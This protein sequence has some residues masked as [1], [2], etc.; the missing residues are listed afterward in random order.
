MHTKTDVKQPVAATADRPFTLNAVSSQDGT[1]IGYRQYG[2]G[3]GIVLVQGAM[4]SV[5]N[6]SQ[7]ASQ[8]AD[9]FTVYVPDRRGRGLSPLP[10]HQDHTIQ[11]DAEDLE[12]LLRK[13][14]AHNVFALSSGAVI[15]LTTAASATTAIHKLVACEPPLFAQHPMPVAQIA[16]FDRAI[17]QGKMAAALT[18]AGKVV[19]PA[20][21]YIPSWLLTFFTSR[22]LA[23][24]GR[25][26][27]GDF[28]TLKELAMA[29]QY[30]FRVV[31]EM[32]GALQSWSMI[33][34]QVLLLGGDRSPAYLQADLGAL[35]QV[36]PHATRIALSGVGHGAAWNYDKQRNRGGRPKM[37][38]Q[39]L[40]QFFATVE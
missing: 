25:Q 28:L 1:S 8:L 21:K 38:A 27:E 12:A 36:L 15:A 2:Q 19:V 29:L 13:T 16:H 10:Y 40:R 39:A 14:E 20:L 35:K 24:E 18:A 30:D 22:L 4:G 23:S 33:Q 32:H 34:A 37:V 31:T 11:R 3:P 6:F 9:T 5:Q 26:P 7:L 17:A